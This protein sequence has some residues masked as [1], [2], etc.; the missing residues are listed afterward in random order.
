MTGLLIA[1][2]VLAVGLG[3][4]LAAL[5][6][7][8]G[9]GLPRGH[10]RRSAPAP[11]P[12]AGRIL[13][14]FTIAGLSRRALDAALRLARADEAV[15]VPVL[16]TQ[17]PLT[18]GLETPLPRQARAAVALQEAV[19]QRATQLGIAVDARVHRGRSARHALRAALAAERYDRIVVAAAAPASHGFAPD[20]IAW[21]LSGAPGEIVVV[22]AANDDAWAEPEAEAVAT[23]RRRGGSVAMPAAY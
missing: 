8:R 19:E 3:V 2:I 22:R 20:D 23:T 13:F 12:A 9:F 1:V 4:A 6:R 16:L 5:A 17:V 7:G 18:L 10:G 15:L 14:P 11:D 21:L